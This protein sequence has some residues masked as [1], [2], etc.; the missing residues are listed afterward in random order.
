MRF[1]LRLEKN[2]TIQINYCQM[3]Y[4]NGDETD[5]VF[6]VLLVDFRASNFYAKNIFTIHR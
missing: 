3:L 2:K 6:D 1:K 5:L 4:I